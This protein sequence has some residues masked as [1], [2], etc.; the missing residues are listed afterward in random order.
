MDAAEIE[1]LHA[2]LLAAQNTVTPATRFADQLRWLMTGPADRE[3]SADHTRFGGGSRLCAN[4]RWF[5]ADEAGKQDVDAV[6]LT[7][8]K[9][10]DNGPSQAYVV[11]NRPEG[12]IRR[13]C[14]FWIAEGGVLE[15]IARDRSMNFRLEAGRL[16]ISQRCSDGQLK[17]GH[18]RARALLRGEVSRPGVLRDQ[19]F[20][21]DC[22]LIPPLRNPSLEQ[23]ARAV[24]RF[25]L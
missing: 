18:N 21:E 22:S 13:D 3:L 24:Q 23:I 16:V 17:D 5:I 2:E 15:L 19:H 20:F 6:Y 10:K 14:D 11:L 9:R 25:G 12:P 8:G 7:F 4:R 1:K